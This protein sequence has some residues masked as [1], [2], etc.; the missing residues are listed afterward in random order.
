MDL[1]HSLLISS[2]PVITSKSNI[3]VKTKAHKLCPEAL[4]L[5]RENYNDDRDTKSEDSEDIS[6]SSEDSCDDNSGNSDS[7]D[8][9]NYDK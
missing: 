1:M 7:E 6:S 5:L 4:S 2:D 8:S 3:N 9:V